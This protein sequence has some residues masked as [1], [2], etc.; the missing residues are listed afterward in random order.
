MFRFSSNVR[1]LHQKKSTRLR[2][3]TKFI[4]FIKKTNTKKNKK[5]FYRRAN[6]ILMASF[7]LFRFFTVTLYFWIWMWLKGGTFKRFE[8]VLWIKHQRLISSSIRK[9]VWPHY[10]WRY[11]CRKT[12]RN[13]WHGFWLI[14]LL[15][16]LERL[17][18]RPWIILTTTSASSSI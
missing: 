15:H 12:S 10:I 7:Y 17:I 6:H 14:N 18:K 8:I 16:S 1:W 11:R 3:I 5:H 2:V 9:T 4:R 13:S